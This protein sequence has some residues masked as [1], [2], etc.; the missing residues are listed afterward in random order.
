[1]IWL[2]SGTLN[3]AMDI[4]ERFV[5]IYDLAVRY[6]LS[7]SWTLEGRFIIYI[8]DIWFPEVVFF[9]RTHDRR[10]HCEEHHS[11]FNRLQNSG[12]GCSHASGPHR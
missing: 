8:C 3:V 2:V 11:S 12:L 6:W 10:R 7:N 4:T 5:N 9:H 1:M